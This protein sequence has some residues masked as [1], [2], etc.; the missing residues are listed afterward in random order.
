VK[1]RIAETI[2]ELSETF[3]TGK[4]KY[5]ALPVTRQDIAAYAG[6]TY[7]TVFK[8]MRHLVHDKTISVSG[9]N[10]RVLDM[11]KLKSIVNKSK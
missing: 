2:L 11:A 3:G 1:G 6:T 8:M 10:I 7:E 5:I 9:K 4:N